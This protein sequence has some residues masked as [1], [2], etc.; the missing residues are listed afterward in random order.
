LRARFRC[1]LRIVAAEDAE[2]AIGD[3]IQSGKALEPRV[4]PR[5]VT[6][7]FSD[8]ESFTGIAEHLSPQEPSDQ[9]SRYFETITRRG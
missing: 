4:E 9:T 1:E 6:L 2:H 7:T 8:I 5:F 3:L